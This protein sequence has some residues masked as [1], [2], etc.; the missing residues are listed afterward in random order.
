MRNFWFAV[1]FLCML[2]VPASAQE[3]NPPRAVTTSTDPLGTLITII[4]DE[5]LRN[6]LLVEI[7][8]L[9][10]SEQ[11]V[12]TSRTTPVSGAGA[13]TETTDTGKSGMAK[14]LVAWV[15]ELAQRL[16][17]AALG[18]PINVKIQEAEAQIEQR[19]LDSDAPDKLLDFS[20][21]SFPGWVIGTIV[22][23]LALM[24]VRRR[25]RSRLIGATTMVQ[26]A[27]IAVLRAILGIVPLVACLGIAAA[28]ANLLGFSERNGLIFF[29]LTA[30][31]AV[32][33]AVSE[34]VS[35]LLLLLAPTKGWRIIAYSQRKLA[36]II[37]FMTGVATAGSLT[38]VPE[39]RAT[40][41]PATL[42]IFELLLDLAVP[43]IAL[44]IVLRHR[45]IVRTLIVRGHTPDEDASPV[46]RATYWVGVHWHH[47]GILFV[48]LNI[49]ARLFGADTGSFL[50]QSFLSVALI[51]L[52]LVVS[53]TLRRYSKQRTSRVRSRHF[54]P[55]V[56]TAISER[57]GTAIFGVVNVGIV[58]VAVVL[59]LELWG[60]SIFS[61][62]SRGP[63][64]S[65]IRSLFSIATIVLMAWLLWIGLDAW[66]SD[67]LSPADTR[68]QR[69]RSAR[70]KTL[71]PLLRN[72][73]FVTLTAMTVI[74][75]LS[76]L[77]INVAPLIAGAGVV[78]LAVGFG[79][80]QLVQDVITGLFIL[81]EDTLAIGD[82]V[83]TGGR[84]GTVEALTIRTVKIRDADGALHSI[85]FSTIKALKNSSRGFG[86]Y[87]VNVTLDVNADLAR[88]IEV[89]KAVGAEI[90]SDPQLSRK[91]IESLDVWGVDQIGLDG[92]VIK[93][94]IKTLPLQ[95][96]SVGR[97][98]NRRVREAL[99]NAGVLLATRISPTEPVP[100]TI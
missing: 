26:V 22:A 40:I 68:N 77:G 58:T 5:K 73:A 10:S 89:F 93:A 83:D 24:M 64:A 50:T 3:T 29:L 30:P 69:E 27:K 13:D 42:D 81:I 82:S 12:S 36:P 54:R 34:V 41:G 91:I 60:V 51:T 16:P 4:K 67:A 43:L 57:L 98:I 59:C 52:A 18:A 84:A 32:A 79:S 25:T 96:Y 19:L 66:I 97:E 86:V 8:G 94:S 74:G 35:S 20:F 88:A 33:I 71:L 21:R 63:G 95:Q 2:V 14:A 56:R 70:V 9:R 28:W 17:T 80:Q 1:F 47:L 45:R 99:R 7:E 48:A 85:P 11:A 38:A 78:G 37:G 62:M 39:L 75:V 87:T 55:G 72:F 44:Y 53:A 61:W 15:R 46:D 23:L 6:D 49:G 100:T 90:C 92:I 76:H 65:I 31:F